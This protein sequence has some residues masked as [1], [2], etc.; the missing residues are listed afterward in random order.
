MT[1]HYTRRGISGFDVY[2]GRPCMA[3]RVPEADGL[4]CIAEDGDME[5]FLELEHAA[6]VLFGDV[7]NR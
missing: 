3:L 4:W 5:L 6:G 2:E 1:P 7:E